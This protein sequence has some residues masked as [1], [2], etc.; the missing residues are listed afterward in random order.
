MVGV[1]VEIDCEEPFSILATT[2]P[3]TGVGE[4]VAVN[5]GVITRGSVTMTHV[6]VGSLGAL[7][8]NGVRLKA[9]TR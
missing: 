5:V 6:L 8:A 7:T 1:G 4:T 3:F 9:H 2:A